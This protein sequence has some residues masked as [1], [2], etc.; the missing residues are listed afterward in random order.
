MRFG[1]PSARLRLAAALLLI[2]AA[3]AAA[4]PAG[5]PD[6]QVRIVTDEA[7]AALAILGEEATAGTAAP[8]SW[9]RL[10]AS[11]GFVRLKKRA[12]S[13]GAKDV[14]GGLRDFLS[15]SE[16]IAR[17]GELRS[18]VE[19]WKHLDVKAAAQR[20]A[21]YLPPGIP[22][23]A[24]IYPVIK[25]QTNSFVF[26]LRSNPAIFMFVD[27]HIAAAK[28]EN[29]LS[30]ELHHV[31]IAGCP[32]PADY[33][34]LSAAQK[35]LFDD[36]GAFG[37]G[38]AMLAAAGGPDVH[39]HATSDA[40]AWLVWERDMAAFNTDLGRLEAFFR[41]VL[42]GKLSEEEA[43]RRLFSFIDAEGV[44][45]GPFYTVGWKMAAMIERARGRSA[46]VGLVCDPRSLLAAY[47][48]IASAHARNDG[49]G[50]AT[51]SPDFLA[52]LA[53]VIRQASLRG[54]REARR[55]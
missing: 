30:H 22:L 52:A 28:L 23:R 13:F 26:E 42:A 29:T 46:L 18:A 53:P 20:A 1:L 51:W 15:S 47:N 49:E 37:E 45:Q 8:A 40:D 34:R 54:R 39:P 36:L 33:D 3:P 2:P 43:N 16:T 10:W 24:T 21:A 11:E 32:H 38:L 27:P 41:D 44:P 50:L 6:V 31:G 12:E 55:R 35:T 14:E 19:T 48:E 4:S 5:G 25:K 17:R 7:D 9:E